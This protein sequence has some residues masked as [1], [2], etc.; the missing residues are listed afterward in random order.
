MSAAMTLRPAGRLSRIRAEHRAALLSLAV[1]T[2]LYR[3]QNNKD[4]VRRRIEL[5]W[6]GRTR[7]SSNP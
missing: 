6:V 4:E 7:P 2:A 3:Q 5:Q 1:T